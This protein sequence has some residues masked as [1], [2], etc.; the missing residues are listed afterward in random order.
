[1]V[2][3]ITKEKKSTASSLHNALRATP[4]GW[5]NEKLIRRCQL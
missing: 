2:N 1:M 5:S 4:S 3:M